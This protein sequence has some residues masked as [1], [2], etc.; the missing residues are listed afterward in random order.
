V[1]ASIGM[2][3]DGS[4]FQLKDYLRKSNWKALQEAKDSTRVM[5]NYRFDAVPHALPIA[6]PSAYDDSLF[7]GGPDKAKARV[8]KQQRNEDRDVEGEEAVKADNKDDK[9][10]PQAVP[11]TQASA[12]Q[13]QS[14]RQSAASIDGAERVRVV[15]ACPN[16]EKK[17]AYIVAGTISDKNT[18]EWRPVAVR[19]DGR[20]KIARYT[21]EPVAAAFVT[22]LKE[23]AEIVVQ[24]RQN[25]R[26]VIKARRVVVS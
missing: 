7:E 8:A 19:I 26:G 1:P 14:N 11:P 6:I 22:T 20:T 10:E 13:Q 15:A 17:N 21:G 18:G 9:A 24:G 2:Q 16:P 4:A 3:L 12:E 23:A 25:K 5:V